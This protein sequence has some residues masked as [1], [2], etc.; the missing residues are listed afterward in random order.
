M[1]FVNT[2]PFHHQ[3]PCGYISMYIFYIK[4]DNL[5]YCITER[6]ITLTHYMKNHYWDMKPSARLCAKPQT[7]RKCINNLSLFNYLVFLIR[8]NISKWY[9]TVFVN[10]HCIARHYHCLS[11]KNNKRNKR[12]NQ[13]RQHQDK[14]KNKTKQKQLFQK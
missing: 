1:S 7:S 12:K 3:I 4:I 13:W 2:F 11:H 10:I 5:L 8:F 14:N 9:F 6:S